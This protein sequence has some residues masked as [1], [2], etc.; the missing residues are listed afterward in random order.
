M[1]LLLTSATRIE[2][3][4]FIDAFS[5]KLLKNNIL[6]LKKNEIELTV[7]I[8]GVGM[9]SAIYSLTKLLNNQYFDAALNVGVAGR[10]GDNLT[11]G[12][13][14]T[15]DNE[16]FAD[17]G[18]NN[19]G[20][21]TNLFELGFAKANEYPFCEGKLVAPELPAWAK[22]FSAF[23]RVSGLSVNTGTGTDEAAGQLAQQCPLGIE[24][25]ESAAFFYVC[26]MERLPFVAVR[27]ISNKVEQRNPA[28]WNIPFAVCKLNDVLIKFI[29][30][31]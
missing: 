12:S 4:P 28:A 6:T 1:K 31:L 9:P 16:R 30:G 13:I 7:F 18:I 26:L 14:V 10:Y 20:S 24:T 15:V 11:M 19:S 21:F 8:S 27:S 5:F 25:M 23:P 22:F 2:I 3:Q 29:E 17:L